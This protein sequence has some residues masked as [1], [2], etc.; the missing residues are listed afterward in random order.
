MR[1]PNLI[2]SDDEYKDCLE[3][4]SVI[5]SINMA[6]PEIGTPDFER[7]NN[8]VRLVE[9]Y[10]SKSLFIIEWTNATAEIKSFINY[11]DALEFASC[12]HLLNISPFKLN[13]SNDSK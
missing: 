7:F 9:T 1:P 3:A 13:D 8:L 5:Y 6:Q 4:L 2:E 11:Q 12:D 10:D